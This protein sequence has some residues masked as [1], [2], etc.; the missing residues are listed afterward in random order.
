MVVVGLPSVDFPDEGAP[1]HLLGP[2]LLLHLVPPG[3]G[4]LLHVVQLP[5]VL[6]SHPAYL[7]IPTSRWDRFSGNHRGRLY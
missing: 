5:R 7:K 4:H 6:L 1:D 2:P 3:P